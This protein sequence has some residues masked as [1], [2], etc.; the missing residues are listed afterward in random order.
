MVLERLISLRTALKNPLAMFVVGGLVAISSLLISFIVFTESVGLF[1]TI[2]ITMAMTPFMVNLLYYEEAETESQIAQQKSAN[3][4]TRHAD[5]ITVY[6]AFFLGMVLSLSIAFIF[7]PETIVEK[8]FEDQITEIDVIRGGFV[9][10]SM[11]QRILINNIGVLLISFLF[12]FLFGSGAIFILSWNASVLSTAIGLAAKSIG[13]VHGLPLAVMI[14]FPHGSLEILAYF[15]GAIAGGL[16]SAAVTRKTSKQ[17]WPVVND[18]M[19]LIAIAMV[20]LV[21]AAFIESVQI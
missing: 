18:S 19:K 1:T 20:F 8:I 2:L 11:F 15:V 10:M 17:F 12:S 6:T 16:V 4:I 9:S 3:F 13:G 5:I 21:V 14:F 7:L